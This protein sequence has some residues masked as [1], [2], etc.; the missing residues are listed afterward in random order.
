MARHIGSGSGAPHSIKLVCISF[1]FVAVFW[2]LVFKIV[3]HVAHAGLKLT[4]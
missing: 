4:M 3:S 1:G 2:L